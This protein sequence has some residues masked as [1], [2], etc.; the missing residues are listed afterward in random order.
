MINNIIKTDIVKKFLE[1]EKKYE[2]YKHLGTLGTKEIY[3][4]EFAIAD[5]FGVTDINFIPNKYKSKIII[6]IASYYHFIEFN[7]IPNFPDVN[8]GD[9][10][11]SELVIGDSDMLEYYY[12]YKLELNETYET[13]FIVNDECTLM[14]T[15]EVVELADEDNSKT[16]YLNRTKIKIV[17][18][19]IEF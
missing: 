19:T 4:I 18:I 12:L 7:E 1:N 9:I 2:K 14:Y 13:D 8:I 15:W 17:N 11:S 6:D 16:D 10:V 3:W 5:Y